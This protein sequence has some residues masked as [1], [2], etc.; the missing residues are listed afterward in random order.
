MSVK[1]SPIMD[2]LY[3]LEVSKQVYDLIDGL[4]PFLNK[5][6]Q[7]IAY[8]HYW[9]LPGLSIRDKSLVTL[10]A[11]ISLHKVAQIKPHLNGFLNT[12]GT[13]EELINIL[14]YISRN[15]GYEQA[16]SGFNIFCD[17]LKERHESSDKINEIQKNFTNA[18]KHN[19][20]EDMSFIRDIHIVN[21]ASATAI[22]EQEKM[23]EAIRNFLKEFDGDTDTLKNIFIHL[24]V[25]CGFPVAI[26][27]FTAF[28]AV[29]AE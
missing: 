11:L 19:A 8:D 20:S 27:G 26:N 17:I 9:A 29:L 23:K 21:V 16:Q 7:E 12:G 14:L 22:G 2:Q 5:Q 4:D 13:K 6:V 10:V 28:K 3:G 1:K 25:Y 18:I 15:L 24:I